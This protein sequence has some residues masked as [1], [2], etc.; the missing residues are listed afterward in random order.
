MTTPNK[1]FELVETSQAALQA[2]TPDAHVPINVPEGESI[3]P[4]CA[5]ALVKRH[6]VV[7]PAHAEMVAESRKVTATPGQ[8]FRKERSAHGVGFGAFESR[9][10]SSLEVAMKPFSRADDALNEVR[11]ALVL[12]G[13]DVETY[14]PVGIF[15]AASGEGFVA[16]TVARHDLVSLDRAEWVSRNRI[17]EGGDV[18]TARR[19]IEIAEQNNA[20]IK[21]VASMLGYVHSRGV[22][23]PDGQIKNFAMTPEGRVGI[24]DAEGIRKVELTDERAPDLAW[25]DIEKLVKSLTNLHGKGGDE[26]VFGVG[27]LNGL[28]FESVRSAIEELIVEPYAEALRQA[29]ESATGVEVEHIDRLIDAIFT[30]FYKEDSQGRATWPSHI[31]RM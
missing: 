11:G 27:M 8:V 12:R 17:G 30:V 28:S 26:N 25:Q 6:A 31:V 1:V 18:E 2:R 3:G 13:L 9:H 23:H 4:E 24:I 14:E 15:P 19:D 5:D 10:G 7:L 16:V 21:A 29:R 20:A 22:F